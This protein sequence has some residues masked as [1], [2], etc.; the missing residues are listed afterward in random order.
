MSISK[1]INQYFAFWVTIAN[2]A[3]NVSNELLTPGDKQELDEKS[4]LETSNSCLLPK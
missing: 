1:Y 2:L 3:A 4:S